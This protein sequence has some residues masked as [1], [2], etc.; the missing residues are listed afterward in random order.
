MNDVVF[1]LASILNF[2]VSWF[3]VWNGEDL[4]VLGRSHIPK[5]LQPE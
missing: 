3:E 4:W 2:A 1:S 5:I